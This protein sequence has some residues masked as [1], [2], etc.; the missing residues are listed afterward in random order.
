MSGVILSIWLV[1][2]D[3]MR[4]QKRKVCLLLDNCTVHHILE[5]QLKNVQLR[6]FPSMQPQSLSP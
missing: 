3:D 2:F 6:Y 4:Q 1:E 5:L